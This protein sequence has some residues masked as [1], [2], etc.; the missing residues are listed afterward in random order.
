MPTC[1]NVESPRAQQQPTS[2]SDLE[3]A[4]V[5][6]RD[7]CSCLA[8]IPPGCDGVQH[9]SYGVARALASTVLDM[10]EEIRRET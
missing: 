6:A 10:L 9:P 3:P 1:L 7:L 4:I 8:S 2:D 5:A